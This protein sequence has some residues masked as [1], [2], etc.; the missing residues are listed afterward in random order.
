MLNYEIAG[1]VL[2]N[3]DQQ[4]LLIKRADSEK[5]NE[6]VWEVPSGH[7][8]TDES[9]R[10]GAARETQEEVGLAVTVDGPGVAF[11]LNDDPGKYGVFYLAAVDT[12]VQ[13]EL[14]K[15][16]D[17]WQWVDIQDLDQIEPV[18]PNF[19]AQLE[20]LFSQPK[21]PQGSPVMSR[22]K[23]SA[24]ERE[25]TSKVLDDLGIETLQ[26][27][28]G[29][30]ALW[31]LLQEEEMPDLVNY[32]AMDA[33][34]SLDQ[35]VQRICKESSQ[36]ETPLHKNVREILDQENLLDCIN[37]EYLPDQV[38]FSPES[39]DA[40]YRLVSALRKAGYRT[41]YSRRLNQLRVKSRS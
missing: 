11:E 37:C 36:A 26:P 18:H 17:D 15:A 8:R 7:L 20:F 38:R 23:K 28:S 32:S 1:A 25:K 13:P 14:S 35:V 41:G 27:D 40:T 12:S 22:R 6:G 16:H 33:P 3:D 10:E 39:S 2:Y 4:I 5:K 30:E 31:H 34:S 24:V 29:W 21:R 19:V 9:P